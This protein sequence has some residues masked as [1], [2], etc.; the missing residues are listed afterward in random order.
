MT[1]H[2][3]L[4]HFYFKCF[5]RYAILVENCFYVSNEPETFIL[6][7]FSRILAVVSHFFSWSEK[8][9]KNNTK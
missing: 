5:I 7:M 9:V 4:K 2:N 8:K 1:F 6:C 3:I